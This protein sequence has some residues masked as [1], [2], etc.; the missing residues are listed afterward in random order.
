MTRGG[1]LGLDLGPT[2]VAGRSHAAVW[3]AMSVLHQVRVVQGL[4]VLCGWRRSIDALMLN[5]D[6]FGRTQDP[7]P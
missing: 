7:M 5:G 3:L 1:G 6:G 4:G 2:A